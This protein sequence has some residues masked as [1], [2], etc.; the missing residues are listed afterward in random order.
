MTQP[1]AISPA[2]KQASQDGD[3]NAMLEL[4]LSHSDAGHREEAA[5]WMRK[6]A[7]ADLPTA[8]AQLGLW[9]VT[10]YNVDRAESDGANHILD[11]ANQG[12]LSAMR[13]AANLFATGTG[14][15][16]NWSKALSLTIRAA[17][18][19]DGHALLV[20]GVL[21]PAL[22]RLRALKH[23][24]LYAAASA[25]LDT[26]AHLL[27]RSLL[28][29]SNSADQANGVAWIATA[30]K[31]GNPAAIADMQLHS[32]AEGRRR[33]PT[34]VKR[35]PWTDLRRFIKLP[36]H[37]PAPSGH[38]LCQSP[39]VH[40]HQHFLE[41]AHAA[42][43]MGSARRHLARATVN[44]SERGQIEDES[45][46]NS[47]A[48]FRLLETDVLIQSINHRIMIAAGHPDGFGD[49]LSLLHYDVGQTYKPHFDFFDPAFPGHRQDLKDGGQRLKT[50]LVYL[51]DSFTGG[52]TRFP[53]LGLDVVG[54]IGDLLLFENVGR[55]GQPDRRTLHS[56]EPPL[57]GEKWILSKW[58]RE[59]KLSF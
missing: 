8:K 46:S 55:D 50:A 58:I 54:T 29:E 22:P 39:A 35:V 56:G 28:Q 48:N 23:T 36:H 44:D 57:S 34:G 9:L 43:I 27:G 15:P 2:L 32:D 6:A 41:P 40:L 52:A 14:C 51:N 13:L 49:P 25:G 11:A 47:F 26:A 16:Q 31:A 1:K 24:L 19:G 33:A 59:K 53:E 38:S 18:A 4:A 17:K 12:D 37:L 7:E 30:A 45:R 42:Y 20:A 21:L 5:F 10:G 3:P